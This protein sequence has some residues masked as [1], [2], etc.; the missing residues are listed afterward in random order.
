ML[1]AV[2]GLFGYDQITRSAFVVAVGFIPLMLI[3]PFIFLG[4]LRRD[5]LNLGGLNG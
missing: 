5:L 3:E 2:R 4:G 1:I